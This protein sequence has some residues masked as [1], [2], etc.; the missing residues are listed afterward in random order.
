MTHHVAMLGGAVAG[1]HGHSG[2]S[3]WHCTAHSV[4]QHGFVWHG[5]AQ[6]GLAQL[7][8]AWLS[9]A[10]PTWLRTAW[11]GLARP[12]QLSPVQH[13]LA[14]PHR[15]QPQEEALHCHPSAAR[16]EHGDPKGCRQPWGSFSSPRAWLQLGRLCPYC[17]TA[18]AGVQLLPK[19]S[20]STCFLT[21]PASPRGGKSLLSREQV[22]YGV[23]SCVPCLREGQPR[24]SKPAWFCCRT[25]KGMLWPWPGPTGAT[26]S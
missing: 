1:G 6:H 13:G 21:H 23:R 12:A 5:M 19:A 8:L 10:W 3:A 2:G 16:A 4:V 25:H 15:P 14:Q 17:P 11:L 26:L 7:G 9:P 22:A 18:G 24:H 20:Q